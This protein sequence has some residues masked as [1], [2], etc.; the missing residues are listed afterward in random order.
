MGP[1]KSTTCIGFLK[2]KEDLALITGDSALRVYLISS[3]VVRA[4]PLRFKEAG[5]KEV[6]AKVLLPFWNSYRFLEE[7]ITLLQKQHDYNFVFDPQF[8]YLMTANAMDKWILANCQSLLLFVDNEMA[9]K[10][11]LKKSSYRTL[12]LILSLYSLSIIH[13]LAALAVSP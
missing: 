11:V 5:V 8:D 2:N 13:G 6:V 4:E 3:P 7:Q 10:Q 9:G 12:R 1:S